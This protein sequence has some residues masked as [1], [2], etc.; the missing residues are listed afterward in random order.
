MCC[1]LDYTKT[2]GTLASKAAPLTRNRYCYRFEKGYAVLSSN[3]CSRLCVESITL[4]RVRTAQYTRRVKLVAWDTL[5]DNGFS[6]SNGF[7]EVEQHITAAI[8]AIK[9]PTGSHSFA[10]YPES[11]KKHGQG[12]GVRPIKDAFIKHLQG[13]GWV[14][15][16]HTFDAHYTFAVED[17]LPFVVEWETGNISSSHRAINRMALGMLERRIS[18]GVLVVPSRSLYKFLTDRVG[19]VAELEPYFPLWRVW[20]RHAEFGYLAIIT[21]EHDLESW[22]VE[23][24]KKGTDGWALGPSR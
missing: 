22:D 23:R 9:W 17:V 21:V 5:V 7:R 8:D 6:S 4:R 1:R 14:P 2:T 12:N 20:S 18:G 24:I 13:H 11:G 3:A 15:E 16:H 19:N 10:I